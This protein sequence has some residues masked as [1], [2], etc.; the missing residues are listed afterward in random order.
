MESGRIIISRATRQAEFPAA[1]QFV[2]AMNPC[3]CGYAGYQNDR[4]R[5]HP[6][7][8]QRYQERLSGPFL[9][10]VDLLLEV[11]PV[12]IQALEGQQ[13]AGAPEDSLTIRTRVTACQHLQLKRQNC[14]NAQLFGEKLT[15]IVALSASE[16]AMLRQAMD[17]LQLSARA[18]HR[19]LRLARTIADLAE[20][21]DIQ[22]THLIEALSYRQLLFTAPPS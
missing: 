11:L 16:Q 12:N 3:P 6:A 5:C 2:A 17:K 4:C 7:Q 21:I 9:D 19:I 20:S 18:Y 1:F 10:R 22:K 15:H 14:L 8:V 13:E